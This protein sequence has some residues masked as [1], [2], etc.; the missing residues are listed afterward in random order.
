MAHR[1]K[2][3]PKI[4]GALTFIAMGLPVIME[5]TSEVHKMTGAEL[6]EDGIMED[7]KGKPL[8]K[9][10]V[11]DYRWPV[12]MQRNHYRRLKHRYAE[13]GEPGVMKYLDEVEKIFKEGE[14]LQLAEA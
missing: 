1:F 10:K 14:K 7:D 5:S 9:D 2:I 3:S 12:Q 8:V 11:Y 4:E 13:E 6:M